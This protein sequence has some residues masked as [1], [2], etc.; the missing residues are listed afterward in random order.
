M[1][2][3]DLTLGSWG[4]DAMDPKFTLLALP[5]AGRLNAAK[6]TDGRK[7]NAQGGFVIGSGP[8]PENGVAPPFQITQWRTHRL[9]IEE[10][11]EKHF[12]R[13]DDVVE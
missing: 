13:K 8:Y 5:N 12:G 1:Q 6:D 4:I 7:I 2:D 10:S 9:K 11:C 3:D